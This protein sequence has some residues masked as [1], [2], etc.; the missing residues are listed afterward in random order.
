M[1]DRSECIVLSQR[2]LNR[3]EILQRFYYH[4]AAKMALK[5]GDY[6]DVPEDAPERSETIGKAVLK[7][8]GDYD[9]E[10]LL[11]ELRMPVLVVEGAQTPL[12]V[13]G[14]PTWARSV[15]DGRLWLIDEV[16]HAY[17]F[18]EAPEVFFPGIETFLSGDWPKGA[19]SV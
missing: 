1:K 16:G 13:E 19:V 11:S 8:L 12:P 18:V 7:E 2:E 17:P 6:C 9:F 14:C 3:M 10:P 5:K 15:R 4:D